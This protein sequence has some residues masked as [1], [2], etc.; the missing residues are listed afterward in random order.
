MSLRS[1][2]FHSQNIIAGLA[3]GHMEFTFALFTGMEIQDD[4]AFIQSVCGGFGDAL[5]IHEH[6]QSDACDR[7]RRVG[8]GPLRRK[9]FAA[10][11]YQS[12]VARISRPLTRTRIQDDF[13]I[14]A[15]RE[16]AKSEE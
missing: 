10:L 9:C 7:A 3:Q 12:S 16:G 8:R 5:S 15:L 1:H 13:E 14:T 4:R 2:G 11:H 6:M